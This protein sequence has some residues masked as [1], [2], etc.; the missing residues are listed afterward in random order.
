MDIKSVTTT[1]SMDAIKNQEQSIHKTLHHHKIL[2]NLT[3]FRKSQEIF[4]MR[5]I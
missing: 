2:H 5:N 3:N 4:S 1:I